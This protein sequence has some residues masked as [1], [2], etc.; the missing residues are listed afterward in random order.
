VELRAE[1]DARHKKPYILLGVDLFSKWD[2]LV[3][4]I[5]YVLLDGKKIFD[6][7]NSLLANGFRRTFKVDGNLATEEREILDGVHEVDT[8]DISEED[9]LL[10]RSKVTYDSGSVIVTDYCQDGM[11][12]KQETQKSSGS[13]VFITYFDINGE[14]MEFHSYWRGKLL[15][16][17]FFEGGEKVER[18]SF[19][20]SGK[21]VQEVSHM[22]NGDWKVVK[23]TEMQKFSKPPIKC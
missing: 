14:K 18:Q 7:S 17:E 2:I 5:Q 16:I 6:Y 3:H 15:M 4:G 12:K 21:N 22:V 8:Y 11:T 13:F 10:V 9:G 1:M 23:L 19:D 20:N